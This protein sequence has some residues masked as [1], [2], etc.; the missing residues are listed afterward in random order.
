MI[1]YT[2]EMLHPT[3]ATLYG[4]TFEQLVT[5]ATI[6][7]KE[8]LPPERVSEALTDIDRIIAIVR[9]EFEVQLKNS[10]EYLNTTMKEGT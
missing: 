6:L 5:I 8:G 1:G 4:Y 2:D 7:R 3:P 9:A 10:I